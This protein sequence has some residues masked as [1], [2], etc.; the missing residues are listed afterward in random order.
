MENF[1]ASGTY[2]KQAHVKIPEGLYEEEHGRK[3]FFG[4]VSQLYHEN[5]PTSWSNIEG[6]LKPRNLPNI[7]EETN[8]KN[9]FKELLINNDVRMSL[10]KITSSFKNFW[11][12]SDFDELYF[13]QDGE[14]KVET[15]YGHI[16]FKKGDYIIMPRGTTYKFFIDKASKVLR[17][18]SNSE[19]EQPTRG[20][21]GP[22]ALYDQTAI[23]VPEAA[24]GS[25]QNKK[26][27]TI[28]IKRNG[29]ITHLTYPFN[30]LDVQ[31]WKGSIY[32]WRISIYDFCPINSHKYHIFMGVYS[33]L[34]YTSPSPRDRG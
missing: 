25:E 21:L 27:H 1:K 34:L 28:E 2:T 14:G 33:C 16:P 24:I 7:F 17:I 11:R 5:P 19:F 3:G 13:I 18:E 4:R 32:P 6:S 12:N 9:Q 26:E 10:G 29:E 31:G 15:T 22:N 20:I 23:F 8:L 30:P